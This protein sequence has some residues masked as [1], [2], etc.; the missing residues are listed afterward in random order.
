M[1]PRLPPPADLSSQPP[2]AFPAKAP[3]CCP[4]LPSS[5]PGRCLWH[6]WALGEA[7]WSGE[8]VLL[9]AGGPRAA[10][11]L[12]G[13]WRGGTAPSSFPWL[14]GGRRRRSWGRRGPAVL[15]DPQSSISCRS[16]EGTAGQRP[17]PG[18]AEGLGAQVPGPA[19]HYV[20][21]LCPGTAPA[22]GGHWAGKACFPGLSHPSRP[23]DKGSE[24]CDADGQQGAWNAVAGATAAC[25]GHGDKRGRAGCW[26]FSGLQT[27]WWTRWEQQ[28]L[29]QLGA[30]S[31]SLCLGEKTD[32]GPDTAREMDMGRSHS[33]TLAT[34]PGRFEAVASPQEEQCY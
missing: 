9:P 2:P 29:K 21:A 4:L 11:H 31:R 10:P 25:V 3:G 7:P 26:V 33:C 28:W 15:P 34:E 8:G 14:P 22:A 13:T 1:S 30:Q 18:H 5:C 23:A 16:G 12:R 17:G 19:M 24:F 32:K 20:T 6:P 27:G